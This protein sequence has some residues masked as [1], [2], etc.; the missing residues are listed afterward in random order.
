M[1]TSLLSLINQFPTLNVLVIGEAML[2]CYLSGNSDRLCPE[3]PVP[4]VNITKRLNLPGGAANTAV[5][6]HQ[7]GGQVTLLS[8]I[9]DD[10]EGVTLKQS[11][12]LAGVST[13]EL[14]EQRSRQTLS[15]QR[16]VASSQLVVRFDQ[17]TTEPITPEIET[18]LINR[19]IEL[20]P[21]CNAVVI[22]DYDYGI[23]TPKVIQTV[24]ELQRR[25]PRILVVDSK[26][27]TH[28]RSAGVT[29]VK[30]NYRETA[31][32]LGLK[33][34]DQADRVDQILL[35]GEKMLDLT[36]AKIAAITLDQDGALIFERDRPPH[37]TAA[38]PAPPSQTAG[39]GDTF[40]STLALALAA[41]ADSTTAATLAAAATAVVVNQ[42]GTTACSAVA[43]QQAV[44]PMNTHL[45]A[46]LPSAILMTQTQLERQLDDYRTSNQRIVFTNGCFDILHR[47]HVTYLNQA[48]ALGDVLI[49]GVNTDESVRRLKG[50]TRPVNPLADRMAVLAGLGCVDA[51][52]PFNETT[53]CKLIQ[54]IRPDVFVKGGDYT[55]ET[56]PEAALVEELGGVVKILAYVGDRSTTNLIQ[57]IQTLKP[58]L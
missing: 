31:H 3:A 6:L 4:V 2:D 51:I 52:A 17:G 32:L 11:L 37:R 23:L 57:H 9:G 46:V 14:I 1:T 40:V 48:K 55:R 50:S 29:A 45:P 28:Y 20:F 41:G 13:V 25:S 18:R 53:P 5:N 16:V 27:L 24:E 8:V 44:Q 58:K 38:K 49:V 56:L 47:G 26:K 7:L 43:L 36:G 21:T 42:P 33:K 10:L 22:S 35:Y 34:L 15:K 30:P 12:E 54:T 39:A 19:L